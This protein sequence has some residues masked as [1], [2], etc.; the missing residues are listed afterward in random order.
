M[1]WITIA[2]FVFLQV[3]A[4]VITSTKQSAKTERLEEKVKD[5][6]RDNENAG[7]SLKSL[8][9]KVFQSIDDLRKA[10]SENN[11]MFAKA[12]ERMEHNNKPGFRFT[13]EEM[14]ELLGRD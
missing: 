3:M 10:M 12:I 9:N 6:E 14:K 5:L 13:L 11:L 7:E 1:D 8:E 2:I 4:Q